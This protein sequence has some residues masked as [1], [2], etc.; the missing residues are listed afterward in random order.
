MKTFFLYCAP[1][2]VALGVACSDATDA[3][4]GAQ[5]A[6][7]VQPTLSP[8]E[9]QALAGLQAY[10][11]QRANLTGNSYIINSLR[12]RPA[13]QRAL[14]SVQLDIANQKLIQYQKAI[15]IRDQMIQQWQDEE[16]MLKSAGDKYASATPE[17]EKKRE[18]AN[19][20]LFLDSVLMVT[21][22]IA[23]LSARIAGDNSSETAC[24]EAKYT[25]RITYRNGVTSD[26]PGKQWLDRSFAVIRN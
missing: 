8:E 15:T 16:A 20:I 24:Y 18:K 6:T 26:E 13:T 19:R 4:T 25:M 10:Y 14:D 21:D 23:T 7:A 9:Q 1:C 17:E 22:T 2:L 12:L 3:G 11:Q 5:P